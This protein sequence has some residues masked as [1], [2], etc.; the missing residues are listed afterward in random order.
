MAKKKMCMPSKETLES[1]YFGS[2]LSYSEIGNL[3]GVTP[4]SV[5]LW[6]KKLSIKPRKCGNCLCRPQS[7]A[8]KEKL[9]NANLGKIMSDESCKKISESRKIHGIGHKKVRSDGYIGLFFPE[10]PNST[11]DGYIMEHRFVMEKHLGR[12]LKS[13]EVVHHINH[14]RKDNRIE[15]LMLFPSES[16]HAKYHAKEKNKHA[17]HLC[18]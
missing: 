2:R 12:E 18:A 7:E 5:F 6:F 9:R 4:T 16:E 1:F 15:N 11:R 17:E 8:A 3:F 14:D 13:E 10:H